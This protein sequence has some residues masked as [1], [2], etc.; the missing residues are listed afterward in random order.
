MVC[1]VLSVPL[2]PPHFRTGAIGGLVPHIEAAIMADTPSCASQIF[3]TSSM[4][5][6]MYVCMYVLG[7]ALLPFCTITSIVYICIHVIHRLTHRGA[8]HEQTHSLFFSPLLFSANSS[9]F[10]IPRPCM[11][12]WQVVCVSLFLSLSLSCTQ[13]HAACCFVILIGRDGVN[14]RRCSMH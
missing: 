3:W 2:R 6:C 13:I 5:V 4:Y 7:V 12:V 9:R 14:T 11:C 8:S 10:L 1:V